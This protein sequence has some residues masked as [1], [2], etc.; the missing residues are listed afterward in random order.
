MKLALNFTIYCCG[1]WTAVLGGNATALIALFVV[2]VL[3]FA[4]WRDLRDI[5]VILGFI[6]IGFALE[7]IFMVHRVLDYGSN[8]PP[9]WA[10]CQWAMLAT[11]LR[12]SLSVLAGRPVLA[13]AVGGIVA[14]VVYTNSVY[15]GPVEWA[16]APW[17][18]MLILA[19][20]CGTLVAVISG[21][22]IPVINQLEGSTPANRLPV[23]FD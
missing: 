13:F 9:A 22:L 4:L 18:A 11:T 19:A 8:L 6:F 7:W 15:F 1:W 3:H 17:E 21:I 5:F 2:L 10:I 23:E 12:Y 14:P 16:R 20:C